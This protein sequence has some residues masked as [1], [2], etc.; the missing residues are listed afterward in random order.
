MLLPDL[1]RFGATDVLERLRA[2]LARAHPG[3][4]PRFTVSFGV[5]DTQ[6]AQAASLLFRIAD[7][8]LYA[9]KMAGRDRVTIGEVPDDDGPRR[10]DAP[11]DEDEP[12][13]LSFE[14]PAEEGP[15]LDGDGLVAAAD[16]DAAGAPATANGAGRSGRRRAARV[17][18]PARASAGK[19]PGP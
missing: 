6:Q 1:D 12:D 10:H 18:R 2:A 14:V 19:R 7:E 17:K 16:S 13:E 8:G 9:A 11:A 5:S 15:E 4:T 3:E